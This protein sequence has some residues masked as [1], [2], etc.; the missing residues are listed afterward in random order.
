MAKT[1]EE[2]IQAK[3]AIEADLGHVDT[4][5]EGKAAVDPTLKKPDDS[6]TREPIGLFT[7]GMKGGLRAA[8]IAACHKSGHA[9]MSLLPEE[10]KKLLAAFNAKKIK[11]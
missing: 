9:N 5:V 8:F 3:A 7:A 2:K 10:W 11:E 6:P 4:I 1:T